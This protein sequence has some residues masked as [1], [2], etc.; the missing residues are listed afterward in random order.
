[1]KAKR[2]KRIYISFRHLFIICFLFPGAS[3]KAAVADSQFPGFYYYFDEKVQLN[4]SA[5]TIT[6]CF[7]DTVSLDQRGVVISSEP[8]LKDISPKIFSRKCPEMSMYAY[9]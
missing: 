3:P 4:V 5:E 1:M 9:V 6:V 2:P 8:A 7:E